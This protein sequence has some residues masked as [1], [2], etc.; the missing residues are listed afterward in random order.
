MHFVHNVYALFYIG[1]GVHRLIPQSPD[2]LNAVIGSSIQLQH[3][4]KSAA[5][6]TE[7]AGAAV[8]GVSIF[9]LFAVHRFGQD[10]GAGRLPGAPGTGKQIR[11]GQPPLRHLALERFR[12]MP[13]SHHIFKGLGPPFAIERLI[14]RQNHLS[15]KSGF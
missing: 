6:D 14:Q 7:T 9:R 1:W 12:N 10:L 5:F 4:Q 15:F 8:A 3:V 13:L 2:L 11:M